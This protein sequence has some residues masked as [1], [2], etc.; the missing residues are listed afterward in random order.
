MQLLQTLSGSWKRLTCKYRDWAS[1]GPNNAQISSCKDLLYSHHKCTSTI[2]LG[3]GALFAQKNYVFLAK[4]L[5]FCPNIFET[6]G[7]ATLFAQKN[8]VFLAEFLAFCPNIFKTGGLPPPLPPW[9]VRLWQSSRKTEANLRRRLRDIMVNEIITIGDKIGEFEL[10][11]GQ[12]TWYKIPIWCT[13]N[14]RIPDQEIWVVGN[15]EILTVYGPCSFDDKM[16][17]RAIGWYDPFMHL[18]RQTRQIVLNY[19]SFEFPD[20]VKR[21]MFPQRHMPDVLDISTHT[22]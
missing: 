10:I 17:M 13:I 9:L 2:L 14:Y 7:A 4:F 3:G 11:L 16:N 15:K 1:L 22:V 12:L 8:Y 18:N 21:I 6:G 19:L 20:R 5:A